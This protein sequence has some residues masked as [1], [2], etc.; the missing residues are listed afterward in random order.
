MRRKVALNQGASDDE[1]ED[2]E[3][4]PAAAARAAWGSKKKAY[5]G[6]DS[7]SGS[8]DEEAGEAEEAARLQREAAAA[9]AAGD[10]ELPSDEDDD[11]DDRGTLGAAVQAIPRAGT[12]D[13]AASLPSSAADTDALTAL[14][15]DMASALDDAARVAGPLAADLR[16]GALATDAGLSFLDAKNVLLLQYGACLAFYCLLLA[17]GVPARDH[18]VVSRL[19]QLRAFLERARPIDKRLKYQVDRLLDA[20][21]AARA[22]AE[23]GEG[24]AS[25]GGDDALAHGPR[26]DA[27]VATGGRDAATTTTTAYR[28]PKLA[29]V[30]MDGADDPDAPSL[31]RADRRAARDAEHQRRRAALSG[32]V[33]ELAAEL[34][35]APLEAAV[36]GGASTDAAAMLR[37]RQGLAARAAEE[38]DLMLRVPLTK[39]ERRRLKSARRE[40]M[41]GGA[42][43]DDF[44]ADV[45]GLVS[46]ARPPAGFDRQVAAQKYGGTGGGGA[47]AAL[48]SGDAGPPEP[49]AL[50]DR[51][52]AADAA[53]ARSIVKR[54]RTEAAF[55]GGGRGGGGDSDAD[56][57]EYAAAATAARA[58]KAARRA[59][60]A[61]PAP[62]PPLAP[63]TADGPRAITRAVEKNRGLTPH[64]RRDIKNPR[65][66]GRKKYE[67]AKVRRSG[68]VVAPRERSTAYG[69]E[70]T[71]V[72]ARVSKSVR[73]G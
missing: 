33:R 5:Y 53:R 54:S 72:R 4:V 24:G 49:V 41:A 11:D 73:L 34:V 56:D 45:A 28:P 61:L 58:A 30:A 29:A 44:T 60:Y 65:V 3:G 52:A 57:G 36:D 18:P 62:H 1:D 12:G 10:Y 8:D 50:S 21:A 23:G 13:A 42:L 27:L 55:G 68:Q 9:T 47:R 31:A 70:A 6:G 25:A 7:G 67:K 15:G 63:L 39:D 16:S 46:S 38:E 66:K 32:Y 69:G 26:P 2:E 35:D 59:A 22:A 71:G 17:E 43:L 64:R 19:V 14:L 51:R 37:T 40:G 48:P 20:A